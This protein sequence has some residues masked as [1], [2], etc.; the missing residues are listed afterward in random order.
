MA[1]KKMKGGIDL[2][3]VGTKLPATYFVTR[4]SITEAFGFTKN[5]VQRL[6]EKGVFVAKYPLGTGSRARFIRSQVLSAARALE[7]IK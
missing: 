3:D 2:A 7:A 5:E 4:G 1:A 6:I